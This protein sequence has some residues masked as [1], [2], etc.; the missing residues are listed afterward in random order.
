MKTEM[1]QNANSGND[2]L[3]RLKMAIMEGPTNH[4]AYDIFKSLQ[5][6]NEQAARRIYFHD[7]DKLSSAIFTKPIEELIGC[8][9]HGVKVCE[10]WPCNVPR[11]RQGGRS[12]QAI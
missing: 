4:T 11:G 3:D 6:G 9:L 5:S 12:W 7:G 8:R 2:A 1:T 10:R